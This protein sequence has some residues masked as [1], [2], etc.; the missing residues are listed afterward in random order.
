MLMSSSN[1]SVCEKRG[2]NSTRGAYLP[3]RT[4]DTT[5]YQLNLSGEIVNTWESPEE[6]VYSLKNSKITKSS[7]YNKLI[8]ND[9][10]RIIEGIPFYWLYRREYK[11]TTDYKLLIKFLRYK[12]K[13]TFDSYL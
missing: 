11:S 6:I 9:D 1:Y 10:C 8:K 5:I 13:L 2:K 7:I 4:V 3:K 12:H